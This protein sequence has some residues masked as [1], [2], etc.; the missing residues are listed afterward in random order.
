MG[1][2]MKRR[3]KVKDLI[4]IVDPSGSNQHLMFGTIESID[5]LGLWFTI[6]SFFTEVTIN[7]VSVSVLEHLTITELVI[8]SNIILSTNNE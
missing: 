1:D 3:F 5:P 2:K 4:R 6:Q 7:N 8:L